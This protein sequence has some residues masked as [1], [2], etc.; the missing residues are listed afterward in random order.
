MLLI[1]SYSKY[2]TSRPLPLYKIPANM[3]ELKIQQVQ[4]SAK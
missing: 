3:A 4:D 2:V 1:A